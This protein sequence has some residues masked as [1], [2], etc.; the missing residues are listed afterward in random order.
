MRRGAVLGALVTVLGLLSACGEHTP[1][2]PS[3]TTLTVQGKSVVA[4]K[5]KSDVPNCPKAAGGSVSGGMPQVTL[6][7]LGGGRPVDVADLRGPAIVNF[8]ASWCGACHAEMPALAAYAK[9]HA[10][11]RVIGV[12]FR[13]PQ[14]DSAME[15]ATS[16]KVAYPLVSDPKGELDR[17]GSL[18][19][20][21]GLP[22]TIFLSA[23]GAI[24][25]VEFKAYDTE[26][27]VATAAQEYLG[28]SG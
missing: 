17:A 19:H 18:P 14:P 1:N 11:V 20:V 16:S 6:S 7:C 10:G 21:A 8:W 3:G 27:D 28:T 2:Y 22:M 4:L 25:H 9:S 12:D 13:D 26:Q 15:L 23:D 5:K 24:A